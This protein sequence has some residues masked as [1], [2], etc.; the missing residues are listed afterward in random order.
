MKNTI[1]VHGAWDG[2]WEFSALIEHLSDDGAK[3]TALD[4][5]GHGN[6]T[7]PVEQ[8]TMQAYIQAVMTA[9]NAEQGQ[10]I[11]VGHSLAGASSVKSQRSYLRK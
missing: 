9:V 8:V 11:L 6:N 10:V 1:L 7:L 5:P 4:L 2:S 3:V